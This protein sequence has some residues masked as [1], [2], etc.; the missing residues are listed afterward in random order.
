[1]HSGDWGSMVEKEEKKEERKM[2]LV[3]LNY[4]WHW[5]VIITSPQYCSQH[6]C[7]FV[8][9]SV[10]SYIWKTTRQNFTKFSVFF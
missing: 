7:V 5:N 6:V 4:F 9:L 2:R 3:R 1:M 8:H 10:H